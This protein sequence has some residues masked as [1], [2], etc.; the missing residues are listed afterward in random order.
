[1]QQGHFH[2]TNRWFPFEVILCYLA[3]RT[4][5]ESGMCDDCLM[6]DR[7]VPADKSWTALTDAGRG[8]LDAVATAPATVVLALD[9]DGTLAPIVDDPAASTM[10]QE[11]REAMSRMDGKLAAMAIVTGREVAAV[12][13]MTAVDQQPGL[14]HLVVLGQYGVERYDAASGV[15]RDPE[16]PEAVRLAKGRLEELA[17]ELGREDPRDKGCWIEDKGRAA[18]LHTRRASDPTHALATAV[19]RVREIATDLDLHCEDGRN[20]IEVKSAVT[21]KAQALRELIDEVEPQILIM[22]GDDLGD[23][24]ALEVVAEWINAGRP[25]A[26]VVSFSG[27]QPLMADYADVICDQ[28]EGISAFLRDLADRVCV[29]M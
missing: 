10:A 5:H 11:S 16:V 14:E 2:A 1:M 27:E 6:T 17:E 28:T 24:P 8:I 19:P 7:P 25:G 3:A 26:R 21:T 4:H 20:I 23:V 22:C 29:E 12:R 9:F 15:L 13:R 18:A